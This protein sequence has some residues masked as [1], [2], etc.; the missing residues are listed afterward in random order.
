[1][2]SFK[3]VPGGGTVNPVT[4]TYWGN[5]NG[6]E[7]L[8]KRGIKGQREPAW[9]FFQKLKGEDGADAEEYI[10]SHIGDPILYAV[11]KEQYLQWKKYSIIARQ[12]WAEWKNYKPIKFVFKP[13]SGIWGAVIEEE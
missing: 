11:S 7:W 13:K 9:C 2:W 8:F 6:L 4:V 3:K 10:C 1:M 12:A 5:C